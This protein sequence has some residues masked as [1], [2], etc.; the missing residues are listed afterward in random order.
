MLQ[1]YV[2]NQPIDLPLDVAI[3]LQLKNPMFND[4]GSYS[5]PFT[6]PSSQ[7]NRQVFNLPHRIS[8]VDQSIKDFNFHALFKGIRFLDGIFSVYKTPG[9]NYES[10]LKIGLGGFNSVVKDKTLKDVDYGG[11]IHIGATYQDAMDYIDASVD[12]SYPDYNFVC[13]PVYNPE[14][15]DPD[16]NDYLTHYH[17]YWDEDHFYLYLTGPP[18]KSIITP[19]PYL[20]FV[21]DSLFKT[22]GYFIESSILHT[23]PELRTLVLLNIMNT[24]DIR[25]PFFSRDV[26][27]INFANHVPDI[28][29]LEFIKGLENYLNIQFFIDEDHRK[30]KIRKRDDII[31][32]PSF[33]DFSSN[34]LKQRS[35]TIPEAQNGYRLT[36]TPDPDDNYTGDKIE[37]IDKRFIR[38]EVSTFSALPNATLYSEP[39]DIRLVLDENKYYRVKWDGIQYT[40]TEISLC[41]DYILPNGDAEWETIF[42]T[43]L[44]DEIEDT[45]QASVHDPGP[46]PVDY[47]M[48]FPRTWTVPHIGQAESNYPKFAL[49]LLFYR[50]RVLDNKDLT[51]IPPPGQSLNEP[52]SNCHYPFGSNDVYDHYGNKMAAANYSLLWTG[53][54]GLKENFWKKTLHWDFNIKQEAEFTKILSPLEFKNILYY[55]KYRI[56]RTNFLI[57]TI[58]VTLHNKSIDPATL[59]VFK[60]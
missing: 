37:D 14:F 48:P 24:N 43:P 9:D 18:G 39:G 2:E 10:Y 15:H 60:V 41:F 32:D 4:I 13:F 31:S 55:R 54:Y 11:N 30:V 8:K 3:R 34:I 44:M 45:L 6:V 53:Q 17:N 42:S 25:E 33:V 57:N 21:L 46:P 40:W 7:R 12:N 29:I 50:G 19:F 23:D 52:V 49:R 28:G 35:L 36:Q 22:Y 58:D 1:F 27:F 26:R 5:L 47:Y 56:N 20:C 16:Y 51:G 59:S 38:S